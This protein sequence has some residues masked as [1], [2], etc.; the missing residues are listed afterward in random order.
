MKEF[1]EISG[2]VNAS[3]SVESIAAA[4]E[5][6]EGSW[7]EEY[8]VYKDFISSQPK[9]EANNVIHP[10]IEV[11]SNNNT[12]YSKKSIENFQDESIGR[13]FVVSEKKYGETNPILGRKSLEK[14]FNKLHHISPKTE[15]SNKA[16]ETLKA[17]HFNKFSEESSRKSIHEQKSV[18]SKL[19]NGQKRKMIP[20]IT[21]Q[22]K[23]LMVAEREKRKYAEIQKKDSVM[24]CELFDSRPI[25]DSEKELIY[26][27]YMLGLNMT[28]FVKRGV[29]NAKTKDN[30][31]RFSTNLQSSSTKKPPNTSVNKNLVPK[32]E[33]SSLPW[34][35]HFS[36]DHP[37]SGELSFDLL[38]NGMQFDIFRAGE[39]EPSTLT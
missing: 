5:S 13:L 14:S 20:K 12:I 25:T 16:V 8:E 31:N 18:P 2:D 3:P 10:K 7:N 35:F 29:A 21:S 9:L 23:K 19:N 27:A 15:A 38:S 34:D 32:L 1:S 33:A 30:H 28:T 11:Y 6:D 24:L 4:L 22:N 17:E 36:K 37:F 39:F 26:R